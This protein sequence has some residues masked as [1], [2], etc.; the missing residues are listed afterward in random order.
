MNLRELQDELRSRADVVAAPPTITG[1]VA[2]RIRARQR[3]RAAAAGAACVVVLG[4]GAVV[5]QQ[6]GRPATPTP[7]GPTVSS[8]VTPAPVPT[9]GPDG[10]PTRPVPAQPGDVVRDG[11]R[12]RAKVGGDTLAVA[13]IG[14]PGEGAL[15]LSWTP[16]QISVALSTACWG[17]VSGTG[18][19][20]EAE[21]WILLHGKKIFGS[22]CS[23]S[24]PTPGAL[25]AGGGVPG[26]PGQGWSEL[27]AGTP[28]TLT[29]Q[30]YDLKTKKPITDGSV[31]VA[32][33]IYDLGPQTQIINPAT[34]S[35]V[36]AVPNWIEHEGY[37]YILSGTVVAAAANGRA[38]SSETPGGVPFLVTSGSV[39]SDGE[40]RGT[41]Y[42]T[43]LDEES[44]RMEGGGWI[45]TPQPA[46][47]PGKVTLQREGARPAGY[48]D[49]IAIYVPAP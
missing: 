37:D 13:A 31:R 2:R 21:V 22:S 44:S 5:A 10:M 32:G 35:P 41:T 11:L 47:A 36:A 33:A 45:T 25:P 9:T 46:R 49:F 15:T 24:A 39:G 14:A 40:P 48:V 16:T 7:A 43:G 17:P 29:V 3:A 12:Y 23:S 19:P 27:T 42:L 18:L 34:Q 38:L 4:A 20:P 8:A 6:L 1:A 26:E 30:A 28:T